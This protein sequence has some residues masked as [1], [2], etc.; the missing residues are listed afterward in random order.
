MAVVWCPFVAGAF[1]V[2]GKADQQTIYGF[3]AESWMFFA[4]DFGE[5]SAGTVSNPSTG[6]KRLFR[7][8]N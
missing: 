7:M 3:F 1:P 4:L 6:P 2:Y 8:Q 5:P